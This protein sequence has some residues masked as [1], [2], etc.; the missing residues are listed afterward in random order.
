MAGKWSIFLVMYILL[1]FKI[2]LSYTR[3]ISTYKT[4]LIVWLTVLVG[5]K[6][7]HTIIYVLLCHT[8]SVS[9][10]DSPD[11]LVNGACG[12][13]EETYDNLWEKTQ[14]NMPIYAKVS[15]VWIVRTIFLIPCFK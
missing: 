1:L 14:S 15:G 6:M 8:R 11:C 12:G 4:A 13:E 9:L 10:Q 5:K 2:L 3:S 7:R